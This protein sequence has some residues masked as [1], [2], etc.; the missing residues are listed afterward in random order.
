VLSL[1]SRYR[2]AH[3]LDLSSRL[4]IDLWTQADRELIVKLRND[5]AHGRPVKSGRDAIRALL[6]TERVLDSLAARL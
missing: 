3:K 6:L 5:L 4:A 2:I 1:G